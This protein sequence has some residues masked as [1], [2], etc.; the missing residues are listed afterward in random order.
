MEFD[1]SNVQGITRMYNVVRWWG[2]KQIADDLFPMSN[3][4][5]AWRQKLTHQNFEIVAPRACNTRQYL[6]Y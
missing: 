5:E 1:S 6:G 2:Q 4:R 3:W